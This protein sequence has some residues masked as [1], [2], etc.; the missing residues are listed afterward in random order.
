MNSIRWRES[1][2]FGTTEEQSICFAQPWSWQVGATTFAEV[3]LEIATDRCDHRKKAARVEP[4]L[5][6]IRNHIFAMHR[7]I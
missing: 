7:K 3:I 5:G 6:E 1:N 2:L 4:Q